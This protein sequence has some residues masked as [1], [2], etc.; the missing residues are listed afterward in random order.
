MTGKQQ[1]W[2]DAVLRLI[3][4]YPSGTLFTSDRLRVEAM[5]NKLPDPSHPNAWGSVITRAIKHGLVSKTGRYLPTGVPSSHG[6][7]VA[8]WRKI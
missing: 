7:I 8:E 5:E 1:N 6:R 4:H 2:Y 3:S